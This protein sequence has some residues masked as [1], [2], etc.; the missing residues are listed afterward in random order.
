MGHYRVGIGIFDRGRAHPLL[1]DDLVFRQKQQPLN[2]S[3]RRTRWKTNL[4]F[5]GFLHFFLTM[6]CWRKYY[7]MDEFVLLMVELSGYGGRGSSAKSRKAANSA[8]EIGR[9]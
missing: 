2:S 1:V 6:F 5:R 3:P 4:I 8:A 9:F 7:W